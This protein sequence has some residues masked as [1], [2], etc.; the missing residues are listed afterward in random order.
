MELL[1]SR[2]HITELLG[3]YYDVSMYESD[4][5]KSGVDGLGDGLV[6]KN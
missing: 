4:W 6:G 1:Y 3:P 5:W 2:M